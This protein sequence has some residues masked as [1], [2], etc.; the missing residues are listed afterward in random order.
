MKTNPYKG[1]FIVFE[2]PDG[3]GQTTQ[4]RLLRDFLRERGHKVLLTKE[5]TVDSRVSPKIRA[6]LEKKAIA[7]PQTL[8]LLFTQDRREHLKREIE[9]ALKRGEIVISDRYFFSTFAYG[10]A[11]GLRLGWLININDDF[12]MPDLTFFLKVRPEICMQ[13]IE[14]RKDVR[15]RFEQE[16]K[17]KK[18]CQAYESVLERFKIEVVDGEKP[19]EEV[20]ERVQK[21]VHSKLGL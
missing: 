16:E 19:I 3:S 17:L 14:G 12:L 1:R 5:P 13:R 10:M 4:A 7:D 18:I 21:A 9:P 11:E 8:Q 15:T 6:I 20:A 2:G